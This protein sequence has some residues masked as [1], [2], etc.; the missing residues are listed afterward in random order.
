M[1]SACEKSREEGNPSWGPQTPGRQ[2]YCRR[3]K[4]CP[5]SLYL[6][7]PAYNH[8]MNCW[9]LED[10]CIDC[11][12]ECDTCKIYAKALELGLVSEAAATEEQ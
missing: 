3:I 11:W 4:G 10:G 6:N 8:G 2:N 7:C 5:A 9:E 12:K 1:G